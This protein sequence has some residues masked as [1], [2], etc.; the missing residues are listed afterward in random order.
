M[1]PGVCSLPDYS[2][3]GAEVSLYL[4]YFFLEVCVQVTCCP[5]YTIS[6]LCFP[7][8]AAFA[9]IFFPALPSWT[10]PVY[11]SKPNL[12]TSSS[13]K[14]SWTAP[15]PPEGALITPGK[16]LIICHM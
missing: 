16:E 4:H 14:H 5:Q 2:P 6:P 12:G 1:L 13:K 10:I 8:A 3:S 15:T 9:K 7:Y 11:L